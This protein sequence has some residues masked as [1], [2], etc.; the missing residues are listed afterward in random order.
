MPVDDVPSDR[1]QAADPDQ[2]PQAAGLDQ[3]PQGREGLARLAPMASIAVFD[4]AAP[5]VAYYALR[6]AG[7]STVGALILSGVFPAIGIALGALRHRRLDS[8]GALVLTGIVVGTILGLASGSA[9]LVLLDGTVPTVIFGVACLGSLWAR[10]PLIFYFAL[11]SMGTDTPRGRDF[12]GL[13]RYQG[14]RHAFRVITTVWGL[15]FLAEAA[16][17]VVII[18]TASANTAK[19]S[20]N[21]LPLAVAGLVAAWTFAHGKRSQRLGEL[22]AKAAAARGQTPPAVP[23]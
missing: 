22:A 15:A 11:E 16:V 5:L 14:F 9:H 23:E 12:A 1:S 3:R 10:R 4:V 20:G 18:E 21:L 7:V 19:T 13:W 8:I 17:Q 6:S 2:R